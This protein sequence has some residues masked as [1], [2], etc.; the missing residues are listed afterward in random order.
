[1]YAKLPHIAEKYM[2][3]TKPVRKCIHSQNEITFKVLFNVAIK[4]FIVY[5]YFQVFIVMYKEKKT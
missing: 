5:F 1:M 3:R 2:K 4:F